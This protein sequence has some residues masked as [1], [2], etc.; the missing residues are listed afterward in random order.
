LD[1]DE[2]LLLTIA[3][4]FKYSAPNEQ[5]F[6]NLVLPVVQSDRRIHLVA[7]GPDETGPWAA[8]SAATSGRVCALGRRWGNEAFYAAADVYLDSVPF[9]SITSLLEAG[10]NAVPLLGLR[11]RAEDL[12]LLG[13]GAPGLE[14]TMIVAADAADYRRRLEHLLESATLR[15]ELG[16]RTQ[17]HIR[18]E[19]T[20]ERWLR[21]LRQ[22]YSDLAAA[23]ARGCLRDEDDRLSDVALTHA[24]IGLFLKVQSGIRTRQLIGEHIG[25]LPYKSRVPISWQLHRHGLGLCYLNLLPSPL[26]VWLRQL[27]RRAKALVAA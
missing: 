8:A 13:P 19:H 5:D 24:V 15:H 26:D 7:I 20:G 2:L 4:P 18:S 22:L 11:A 12:D 17:A 3:S 23:G 16:M 27:G 6:L 21:A 1:E 14:N 25:A 9:S 10:A